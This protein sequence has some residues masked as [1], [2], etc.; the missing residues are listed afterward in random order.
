MPV[1]RC[2][3]RD[4]IEGWRSAAWGRGEGRSGNMSVV[5]TGC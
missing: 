2:W 1:E 3:R 4:L 5:K